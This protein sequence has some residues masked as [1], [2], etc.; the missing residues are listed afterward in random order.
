V[1]LFP[2][3]GGDQPRDPSI[4]PD[5]ASPALGFDLEQHLIVNSGY[6]FVRRLVVSEALGRLGQERVA[7]FL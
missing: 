2:P 6:P 4:D 1:I 5:S 7:D 3:P